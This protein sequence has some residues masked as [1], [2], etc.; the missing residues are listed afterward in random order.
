MR[1]FKIAGTTVRIL[2]NWSFQGKLSARATMKC[3][4]ED[5]NGLSTINIGD[6]AEFF[7]GVTK[8]YAGIIKQLKLKQVGL[9]LNYDISIVGYSALADKRIV[10][11]TAASLTAGSIITTH[12]L[13]VLAEEGV[14][15]G[16]I[17]NGPTIDLAVF[18]RISCSKALDYL[19]N[20]TGYSW[21]IDKDKKLNFFEQ[22]QY[23][24]PLAITD[25]SF[26]KGFSLEKGNLDYRNRQYTKAGKGATEQTLTEN[27]SPKPDGT[28]REFTV[29]L[30]LAKKPTIEV[31]T[32]SGYVTV[33]E[34]DIGVSGLDDGMKWY[35]A[36]GSDKISH[37]T[38]ETVLNDPNQVRIT[39]TGLYQILTVSE[40]PVEI[41]ARKN[42]EE[43][44]SGI[45]EKVNY[46]ASIKDVSQALEFGNGLLLKY[47][48]IADKVKFNIY[49]DGLE[50]GMLLPIQKTLFSLNDDFLIESVNASAFSANIIKYTITALDGASVGGWENYFRE[51]LNNDQD[52]SIANDEVLVSLVSQIET[53][54]RQGIMTI[55]AQQTGLVPT[56][57]VVP[58]SSIVPRI[59][60]DYEEEL[61]D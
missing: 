30:P 20:V 60:Y 26:V 19:A 46:E 33:A 50:A 17:A 39:Y 32:G 23:T 45:Y 36:F 38:N 24:A 29:S 14:T 2:K 40:N 16:D 37:D 21:I 5:L 51:L 27:P 55:Q 6:S 8:V 48:E 42:A 31:D 47:G 58:T 18:A 15:A 1:T 61:H 49:D 41:D 4:V 12:I 56:S 22:N 3:T 7:N 59:T 57:S 53:M 54:K 43:G 52:Y 28:S 25:K 9:S 11:A 44:T 34:E 35:F 13:P 10:A